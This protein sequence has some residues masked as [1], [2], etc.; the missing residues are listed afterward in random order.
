MRKPLLAVIVGAVI[1]SALTW[2]LLAPGRKPAD[3]IGLEVVRDIVDIPKMTS[4]TA[5]K[6]REERY[7]SLLTIEQVYAL[8]NEFGRAEALYALAGRVDSAGVQNLIFEANRI[9]DPEDRAG[10]LNILF[11]RLTELDPE[12]ALALARTDSLRGDRAHEQRV[13]IAWARRDLD[14]ALFAAKT[15]TSIMHSISAAQNLYAAFGY[16]GNA[17]TERIEEE[18]DIGPDRTTRARFLYQMADRSPAEAIA[19][20]NAMEPG[21][22]QQEFIS[23]LA[24]HLAQFNPAAAEGFSDLFAKASNQQTFRSIVRSRAAQADPRETLERMLA[25]GENIQ[26]SSEFHSAIRSLAAADLEAAMQYFERIRSPDAR[27]SLGGVIGSEYAKKDPIAALAWATANDSGGYPRLQMQVLAQI[28]VDDPELAF[29]E[30]LAI[31]NSGHRSSLMSN[32]IRAA[33]RKDPAIA[34]ALIEQV[35]NPARRREASSSLVNHWIRTDPDAAI[36]WIQEHDEQTANELMASAVMMITRSDLDSAI[37]ILP[38]VSGPQVQ[39]MRVQVAQRIAQQ[40]SAAEAQSFIRQFEGQ[41]GYR[42]L[43]GA[44]IGGIAQSDPVGAKLLADQLP[45]GAERDAALAQIIRH[46]A[47]TRPREAIA[48]LDSID[49]EVQQGAATASI[50]TS[51]YQQD[52]LAAS[53]WV[54]DLPRGS[55]RDDAIMRMARHFRDVTAAEQALIDSIEDSE[56]RGRA[57][58]SQITHIMRRDP[59]KARKMLSEIDIPNYQRQQYEQMLNQMQGL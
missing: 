53:R 47:A 45:R 44:V 16:M 5:E 55:Q 52:P 19:Y 6:H 37:R 11:F 31:R 40:R 34:I 33:A 24:Y 38:R 28:A 8:P 12:S 27:M 48:W 51:W 21:T 29:S 30:A 10:A 43:Q 36:A 9:A 49:S 18:L 23:W 59:A 25:S 20:I 3:A 13:W 42:Q 7:E 58:L 26:R 50:A 14:A 1:G 46:R 57:Q 41:E 17:T 39:N 2:A 22:R 15:Q 56:K 4:A 54:G 35:D 32:V